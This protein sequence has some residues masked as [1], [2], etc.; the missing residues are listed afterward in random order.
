[1]YNN[2]K[3]ILVYVYFGS[4]ANDRTKNCVNS[5]KCIDSPEEYPFA[6]G[7][8]LLFDQSE[9][10]RKKTY[11][12]TCAPQRR[13]K[14]PCACAVW[15]IVLS[16]WKNAHPWL[17]KMRPVKILIRLRGCAVWLSAQSDQNLRYANMFIGTFP[18]DAIQNDQPCYLGNRY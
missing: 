10:K 9:P 7:S 13:L 15:S 11:F 6:E 12:M 18:G 2:L 16:A 4:I 5:T 14:S 3:E 17:A 1:M 8:Q